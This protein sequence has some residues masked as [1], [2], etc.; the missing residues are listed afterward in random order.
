MNLI[1]IQKTT[2]FLAKYKIHFPWNV[3]LS[4]FVWLLF[5]FFLKLVS[6]CYYDG[7]LH[8]HGERWSPGPCTPE[9]KCDDGKIRCTLIECPEL[10][11]SNPIK[12]RWKCCPECPVKEGTINNS[13]YFSSRIELRAVYGT[14]FHGDICWQNSMERVLFLIGKYDSKILIGTFT[15]GDALDGYAIAPTLRFLQLENFSPKFSS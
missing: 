14:S 11:C 2:S 5:R 15:E 12:K 10:S 13:E 4:V 1:N 6:D 7:I 9:C 8:E 3:V